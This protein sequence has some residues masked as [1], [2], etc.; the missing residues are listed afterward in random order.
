MIVGDRLR[1]V[2][3]DIMTLGV[4]AVVN[5]ANEARAVSGSGV[6][7]VIHQ[8]A[9]SGRRETGACPSNSMRSARSFPGPS[10]RTLQVLAVVLRDR[11]HSIVEDVPVTRRRTVEKDCPG[12]GITSWPV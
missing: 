5:A 12:Q 2:E 8:A 9:G 11:I 1:L 4:A 7:G 6:G 3:G 10:A